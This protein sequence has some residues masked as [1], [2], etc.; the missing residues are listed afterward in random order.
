MM[1]QELFSEESF[2]T[3]QFTVAFAERREIGEEWNLVAWN[4][5]HREIDCHRLY[6]RIDRNGGTARLKLTD[7]ELELLPGRVYFIPAFSVLQSE[8]DGKME[9]YYI[10]FRSDSL[11]FALYRHLSGR[12][13][14]PSD[15]LTE[16]LFRMV[17]EN[18]TKTTP[19]AYMKVRGAMSLL[20]AP[21]LAGVPVDRRDVVRFAPVLSYMEA[22][23]R[24]DLSVSD[25]ASQ[26]NLSTVYFSNAFKAAFHIAPK[27]YILNKRLQE[28]RQLL[29]ETDLSVKEIAYAVGFENVNYFSELFAAR[30]GVSA[31]HFRQR[32][33]PERRTS[34]L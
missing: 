24:E 11:F 4:R 21:F 12:Y 14:V 34:I 27:Q 5:K 16:S 2:R 26:M 22:H 20:L 32:A 31:T 28:S 9:K 3:D 23:F 15:E 30:T 18:Y 7:G 19:E 1:K 33:L 25:L 10:H 8:I 29:L 6:F 17:T 13:S